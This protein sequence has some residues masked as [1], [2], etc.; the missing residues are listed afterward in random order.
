[1]VI[2]VDDDIPVRAGNSCLHYTYLKLDWT[3]IKNLKE[4]CDG[5]EI[6]KR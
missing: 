4:E 2:I 1:M 3:S 6:C 5:K